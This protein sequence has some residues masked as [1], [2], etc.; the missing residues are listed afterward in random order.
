VGVEF[1][2][3]RRYILSKK[4]HNAINIISGIS[5]FG[6]AVATAAL[7]CVLSVFNGFQ[8]LIADLFTAMDPQIKVAPARDKYTEA[9]HPKLLKLKESNLIEVYT[10]VIEDNAMAMLQNRQAVVTLKGVSGN[11]TQLVDIERVLYGRG[12]FMLEDDNFD[13]GVFGAGVLY[14]RFG[15]T[16]D[17]KMPVQVYAPR[18]G[19]RIDLNDPLESFNQ[20]ELFSPQ[21]A[22]ELGQEKYDA[23]YVIASIDFARTLFEKEG[24]LTSV[25]LKLK[26]GVDEDDAKEEFAAIL[27]D[28]FKVQDRYEQQESTFKIMKLEKLIS[29]IFLTF[30]LI[31]ASVNIISSLSMLIIDKAADINT[32]RALGASDSQ[33]AGIF[34]MEGRLISLIGA[35]VGIVVGVVLCLLQQEFGF[36]KFGSGEGS[37]IIDAYPVALEMTDLLIV[38]VTV[39]AV[40]FISVYFPVRRLRRTNR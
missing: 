27:G 28:E 12:S 14:G 32:L 4:S 15:V 1:Y 23:N 5:V 33:I 18:K 22:F 29:Y 17:I 21:V 6:V 20:G 16:A 35:V 40:A 13:Y 39:V 38:F 10:E 25:E 31:V 24:M 37:H 2:I 34:M 26:D 19:E 3:A 11:Y 8:G 36:V 30:I 9:H 7:V